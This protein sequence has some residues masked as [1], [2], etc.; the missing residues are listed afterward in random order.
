[1]GQ[2]QHS[3]DKLQEEEAEKLAALVFSEPEPE[4]S[5]IRDTRPFHR[6]GKTVCRWRRCR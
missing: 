6:S 1:M 3:T 4:T 5:H 2:Y